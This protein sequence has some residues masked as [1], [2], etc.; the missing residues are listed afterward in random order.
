MGRTLPPLKPVPLIS[1]Y[2]TLV[3]IG[4]IIH[5]FYYEEQQEHSYGTY[6]KKKSFVNR[7]FA[8]LAWAWTTLAIFVFY[9]TSGK[10]KKG[11]IN[12]LIRYTIATLY[13]FILCRWAFGPGLFN[14]I[15]RQYGKCEL[16]QRKVEG[17]EG[18]VNANN[19]ISSTSFECQRKHKGRW[20]GF[21]VSGHVFL[22]V[23]CSLF[24][25]EEIWP[26]LRK[27]VYHLLNQSTPVEKKR[28]AK[29]ICLSCLFCLSF[30]LLWFY[31]L[32]ITTTHYHHFREKILGFLFPALYWFIGYHLLFPKYLPVETK[33]LVKKMN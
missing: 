23:H 16:P 24:L 18:D 27:Q 21:D 32:I 1:I 12:S 17:V 15:Q 7:Y 25:L 22:L 5:K 8:K 33:K 20:I 30:V 6:T 29:I 14:R 2:C 9:F 31:T 10:S 19:F 4:S 11:K 13:W 26:V 3:I 28:K